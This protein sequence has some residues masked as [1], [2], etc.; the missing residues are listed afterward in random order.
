MLVIEFPDK[1]TDS[2]TTRGVVLCM[3][4]Q[5]V[6]VPG[7]CEICGS[8]LHLYHHTTGNRPRFEWGCSQG[9]R[10]NGHS[11]IATKGCG[12]FAF[13]DPSNWVPLMHF[14]VLL[15]NNDRYSTVLREMRAMY[16]LTDRILATRKRAYQS[17][18]RT[19]VFSLGLH[20]I[21]GDE[22]TVVFDETMMGVHRAVSLNV[23]RNSS[24]RRTPAQQ[25]KYVNITIASPHCVEAACR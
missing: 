14:I 6:E 9:G 13:T 5:C 11:L 19:A 17:S 3:H 18:L 10:K 20:V 25:V 12:V 1:M 15:K 24:D 7:T 4:F 16:G 2:L 22:E 23:K 21:G 8:K